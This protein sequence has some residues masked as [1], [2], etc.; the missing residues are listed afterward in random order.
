MFL[1][2]YPFKL[3]LLTPFIQ[4]KELG[5]SVTIL[6]S[7]FGIDSTFH[8]FLIRDWKLIFMIQIPHNAKINFVILLLSLLIILVFNCLLL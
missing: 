1:L 2:K 5:T 7:M 4:V 8:Q 3:I 6:K